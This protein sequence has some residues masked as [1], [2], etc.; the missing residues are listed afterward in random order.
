MAQAGLQAS[1]DLDAAGDA[2]GDDKS[3]VACVAAFDLFLD[4][5]KDYVVY[6]P[7]GCCVFDKS[8]TAHTSPLG[9]V[10]MSRQDKFDFALS[11][12]FDYFSFPFLNQE[13]SRGEEA[14]VSI[15]RHLRKPFIG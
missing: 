7:R 4:E 13:V 5:I 2:C 6:I 11:I 8:L 10:K 9:S 1:Q 3:Y 12:V 15:L 14:S